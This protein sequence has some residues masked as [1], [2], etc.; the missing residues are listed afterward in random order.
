[1]KFEFINARKKRIDLL[2]HTQFKLI[3]IDGQ[4]S[5]TTNISSAVT[6]GVDGDIVNN[7]Q[8][9]PRPLVLDIYIIENVEKTKRKLLDIIKLKQLGTIHW[10]QDDRIVEI[11]GNV[12]TIDMPRWKDGIL[13]QITLHCGQPFWES[14]SEVVEELNDALPLHYFTNYPNDMLYF[15]VEG[16]PF[17][18]VNTM[19]TRTIHN[20]G[21]VSVG[22]EIDIIAFDTVTNP[23][24]Y[25]HLGQFFGIGY[26]TGNKQVVMNAGDRMKIYTG[27]NVKA[28]IINDNNLLNKIKPKSTWLQ[29]QAGDNVFAIN[30]DDDTTENMQFNLT[31]KPRYV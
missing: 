29:L 12:E 14:V 23:I 16:I 18:E 11:V 21:D 15:P 2:N 10:E 24:I 7:I 27:R 4:T 20:A 22:L 31:Y 19:R 26:G 3:N 9:Q 25:N 1:M 30:S 13:M 5:A 6:G 28:V 8:A 17:G